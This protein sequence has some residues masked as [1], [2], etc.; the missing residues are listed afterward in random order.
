M[1]APL[2][3][4]I[5]GARFHQYNLKQKYCSATCRS[6]ALYAKR[7]HQLAKV[8]QLS[9]ITEQLVSSQERVKDLDLIPCGN[10]SLTRP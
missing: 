6:T 1:N 2:N 9:A 7:K 5:C 4:V 8:Q 10:K 3:C